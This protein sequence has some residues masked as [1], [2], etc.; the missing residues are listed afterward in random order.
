VVRCEQT[1]RK[2]AEELKVEWGQ[3]ILP[4]MIDARLK[5]GQF[6]ALTLVHTRPRP[7]VMNPLPEIAAGDEEYPDVM[8]VVDCVSSM[9]A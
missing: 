9:T 1:L 2:Q 6:D 7:G 8:F 5:T 4:E 3:P